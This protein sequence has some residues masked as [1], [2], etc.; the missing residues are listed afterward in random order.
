MVSAMAV[1]LRLSGKRPTH[2][3]VGSIQFLVRLDS[4]AE[5]LT[6]SLLGALLLLQWLS[7]HGGSQYGILL[8]QSQQMREF[9]SPSKMGCEEI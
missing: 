1:V 2:A 4:G 5:F 6:G 3:L 8:L 7:P 9:E